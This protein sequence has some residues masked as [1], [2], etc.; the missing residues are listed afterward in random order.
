MGE[1]IVFASTDTGLLVSALIVACVAAIIAFVT[2]IYTI[3]AVRPL[4]GTARNS[5]TAAILQRENLLISYSVQQMDEIQRRLSVCY[6]L[7]DVLLS[8]TKYEADVAGRAPGHNSL[9]DRAFDTAELLNY[10]RQLI[11]LLKLLPPPRLP[12]TDKL[13]SQATFIDLK[14]MIDLA[15]QEVDGA[16]SELWLE[17]DD[18]RTRVSSMARR[19]EQAEADTPNHVGLDG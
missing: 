5:R 19:V 18:L 7:L 11:T 15:E 1:P 2:L 16:M 17:L 6:Q 8:M 3:K 4:E 10:R 13:S 12:A 14:P 9:Q